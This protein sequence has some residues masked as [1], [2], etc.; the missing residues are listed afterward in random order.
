[1]WQTANTFSP[2]LTWGPRETWTSSFWTFPLRGAIAYLQNSQSIRIKFEYKLLFIFPHKKLHLHF[3]FILRTFSICK[4]NA[5]AKSKYCQSLIGNC[6]KGS[7]SLLTHLRR[8]S[9]IWDTQKFKH[10]W[11][12]VWCWIEVRA[13]NTLRAAGRFQGGHS[14]RFWS[15][16]ENNLFGLK[17]YQCSW[18]KATDSTFHTCSSMASH[19]LHPNLH[20]IIMMES[21]PQSKFFHDGVIS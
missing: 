2:S 8:V 11:A 21:S 9:L 4:Y 14:H 7:I 13:P 19:Y 12:W 10:C 6:Y 17:I 5:I 18:V 3:S 20:E 1:M 16:Q 15:R